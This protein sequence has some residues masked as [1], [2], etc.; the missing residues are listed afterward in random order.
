MVIVAGV[1]GVELPVRMDALAVVAEH[2]DRTGKKP[3]ELCGDRG[4]E[5]LHERLGILGEGAENGAADTAHPQWAQ[6]VRAHVETRVEPALAADAAAERDCGQMSVEPVAPLVIDADVVARVAGKL[7]PH[8]GAAMGAA[9]DKGANDALVVAV[10]DDRGLADQGR[11][12]IAGVRDFGVEPEV[13]PHLPL[14]DPLLF[15]LVNFGV[16]VEAVRHPAIVERRPDLVGHHHRSRPAAYRAPAATLVYPLVCSNH[17]RRAVEPLV[18]ARYQRTA[19]AATPR[20]SGRPS[21]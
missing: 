7:A 18:P 8:Q 21:R 2:L 11:V 14:K 15:A 20:R 4:P 3:L 9:V 5:K 16:M 12:E 19:I 17:W 1:L 13:I 10:E 6:A